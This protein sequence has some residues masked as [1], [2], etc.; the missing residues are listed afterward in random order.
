[1]EI[2]Y[3]LVSDGTSDRALIPII[4]WIIRQKGYI[5][6]L[7][8]TCVDYRLYRAHG[9][10]NSLADRILYAVKFFPCDLLFVHRDSESMSDSSRRQ[11]ISEALDIAFILNPVIPNVPVIPIRMTEAWLL[12]RE[13]AIR[14]AA[15]NLNGRTPIFLPD[16]STVDQMPHPKEYLHEQI[17]NAS[18]LNSRRRRHFVPERTVHRVSEYIDDFSRLRALVSFTTLELDIENVLNNQHWI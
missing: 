12:L 4:N 10:G 7:E 14:Y 16:I 18:E 17:V 8:G 5:G 3:T 13:D 9:T 1:M 15:G 2:H 6:N 11:E